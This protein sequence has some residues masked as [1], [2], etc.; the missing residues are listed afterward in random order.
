MLYTEYLIKNSNQALNVNPRACHF[1]IHYLHRSA[2]L[3]EWFEYVW[4]E[5]QSNEMT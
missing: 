3:I 1:L 2:T 4:S 5:R